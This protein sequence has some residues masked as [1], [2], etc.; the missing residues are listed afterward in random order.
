MSF[1]RYV[2]AWVKQ[3]HIFFDTPLAPKDKDAVADAV[4]LI[5]KRSHGALIVVEDGK[6]VGIVTEA[7]LERV[8]RF[9]QLH[10]VMSKALTTL[11]DTVE[12]CE[13]FDLPNTAPRTCSSGGL[14]ACGNFDWHGCPSGHALHPST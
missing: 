14:G 12:A 11:P 5:N 10:I 1:V 6:L 8:N 3:D 13:T 7:I 9:T 2:I 4:D